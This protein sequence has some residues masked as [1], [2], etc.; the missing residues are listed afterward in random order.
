VTSP[1]HFYVIRSSL[2]K[3]LVGSIKGEPGDFS[4]D[5][6]LPADGLRGHPL[7][8]VRREQSVLAILDSVE[9]A[10]EKVK[11]VGRVPEL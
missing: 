3:P 11:D 5:P 1:P 9:P 10:L 7:D 6:H 2:F 4:D 8:E